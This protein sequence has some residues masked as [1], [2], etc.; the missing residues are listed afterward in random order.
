M[1]VLYLGILNSYSPHLSMHRAQRAGSERMFYVQLYFLVTLSHLWR[2]GS[3]AS[4]R[5]PSAP[6]TPPHR[7]RIIVYKDIGLTA[8]PPTIIGAVL[9]SSKQNKFIQSTP[10]IFVFAPFF[11]SPPFF[12]FAS[13]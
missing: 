7:R 13:I 5:Q 10:F 11:S 2:E 6:T 12:F 1:I 3:L 4:C 8:R 9:K